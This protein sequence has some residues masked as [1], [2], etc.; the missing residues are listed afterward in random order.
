MRQE[1]CK[2]HTFLLFP[3]EAQFVTSEWISLWQKNWEVFF[4]S[5]FNSRCRLQRYFKTNIHLPSHSSEKNN[6]SLTNVAPWDG[7]MDVLPQIWFFSCNIFQTLC[8]WHLWHCLTPS[9]EIVL[10]VYNKSCYLNRW[11]HHIYFSSCEISQKCSPL[12]WKH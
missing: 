2:Q 8:N 3:V 6:P 4:F 5:R 10:N 12:H 9:I 7:W 1:K 11:F